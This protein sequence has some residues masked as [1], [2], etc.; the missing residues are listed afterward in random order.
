MLSTAGQTLCCAGDV[1]ANKKDTGPSFV[2]LVFL[3][4]LATRYTAN[5]LMI[6]KE[7]SAET[8]EDWLGVPSWPGPLGGGRMKSV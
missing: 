6:K 2:D 5:H 8:A 1:T 7:V 4:A 3:Q